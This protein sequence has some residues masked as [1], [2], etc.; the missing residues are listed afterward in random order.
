MARVE[1]ACWHICKRQ[2][3][4]CSARPAEVW[5]QSF[6]RPAALTD[7]T[8]ELIYDSQF[9]RLTMKMTALQPFE[10]YET[11]WCCRVGV[12]G[13]ILVLNVEIGGEETQE[14]LLHLVQRRGYWAG[15]QPAQAPLACTTRCGSQ[16]INGQCTNRA[17]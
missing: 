9:R 17:V 7:D 16:P 14:R 12:E 13:D 5:F 4:D 6:S 1:R 10:N 8:L 2:V 15:P 3:D 11:V